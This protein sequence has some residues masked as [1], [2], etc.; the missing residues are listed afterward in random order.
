MA[1]KIQVEVLWVVTLCSVAVEYQH[2]R[3]ENGGSKVLQK[4]EMLH[5]ITTK[6]L[7]T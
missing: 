2:F 5:S 3:D 4:T 6:K 1:V 7:S